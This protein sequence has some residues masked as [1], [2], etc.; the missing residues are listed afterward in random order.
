MRHIFQQKRSINCIVCHK[1]PAKRFE[2]CPFCPTMLSFTGVKGMIIGV[3]K[4]FNFKPVQQ[5]IEPL[6][7]RLNKYGGTV[8]VRARSG[9]TE[10]TI[11]ALEKHS[12]YSYPVWDYTVCL[13]LWHKRSAEIGVRKVLGAFCPATST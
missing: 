4:D 11:A 9:K 5:S 10:A 7:L 3:V 6:V 12:P 1:P 8:V 13:L 2:N